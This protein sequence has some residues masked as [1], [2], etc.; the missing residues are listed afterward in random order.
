ML[1]LLARRWPQDFGTENKGKCIVELYRGALL[2]CD[3][4]I[5]N[6][7]TNAQ[8]FSC[9]KRTYASPYSCTA[10][11]TV[12]I[13]GTWR[14]IDQKMDCPFTAILEITDD[15]G[16]KFRTEM[17]VTDSDRHEIEFTPDP[18]NSVPSGLGY[19]VSIKK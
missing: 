19:S 14:V 1:D 16:K 6:F 11:R 2:S 3:T 7:D 12:A 9:L 8:T 5:I 10:V 4:C 17:V 15:L 13:D 18:F